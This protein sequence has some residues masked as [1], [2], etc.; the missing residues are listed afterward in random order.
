[1]EQKL[2]SRTTHMP[3]ETTRL[4]SEAVEITRVLVVDH[5]ESLYRQLAD[6]LPAG[7]S[8][9]DYA[10]S[11]DVAAA[12]IAEHE[13]D[14]VVVEVD[15]GELDG[16]AVLRRV[17]EHDPDCPVL[18][19]SAAPSFEQ[20]VTALREGAYEFL[21]KPIDSQE[22]HLTLLRAAGR[23][24]LQ[25]AKKQLLEE[26][27]QKNHDLSRRIAE[28]NALADAAALLSSTAEVPRLLSAILGLATKVTM[29][30]IG[31]IMLLEENGETLVI[32]DMIGPESE[33]LI[34]ARLPA[35]DSVAG[36][37]AQ[38]GEALKIDDVETDAQFGRVNRQRF[39]TKSLLSVP[40]KTP[41]R[42][43][44]VINLADKIGGQPFTEWDLRILRTFAAQAAAAISDSEQFQKRLR[45]L[46]EITALYEISR[47]IPTATNPEEL[48]EV[49]FDGMKTIV[50]C[51]I[52]I[53]FE[54][55]PDNRELVAV[56]L[57]NSLSPGE[58][59]QPLVIPAWPGDAKDEQG[60]TRHVL[61]AVAQRLSPGRALQSVLA[62]P[63]GES[64]TP[65]EMIVLLSV[66]PH[67]FDRHT[68]RL[69]RL[70]AAQA[71]MLYERKSA[72]LNASRLV[73]MGKMIS[74]I[75][76]DLRKP[77]TNI[78]GSLQIM[79]AKHKLP[80]KTN[81]VLESTEQEIDLLAELVSELVDFSNPK[82]YQTKRRSLG[83]VIDRALRMVAKEAQKKELRIETEFPEDLPAI[84][85]DENQILEVFLNTILNA[86][87][88][89]EAG[90][91][92]SVRG[93]T[94]NNS[95]S[96]GRSVVVEFIDTGC[97]IPNEDLA[98]IFERYYT[99]RETG[100]GLGLAIV[101]RIVQAHEGIIEVESK[102][103]C[104]CFRFIFPVG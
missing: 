12:L 74:E 20:A 70:A 68:A 73:T 55:C 103:G 24:H 85:H 3:G 99:T 18:V 93:Y 80:G 77:L 102:P 56:R 27:R 104:T 29:A 52:K 9:L 69:V 22:M 76:H 31:S 2:T 17:I 30:R 49:V 88:S 58:D 91:T 32:K 50:D 25:R 79:R 21:L 6:L 48:A 13:Y 82:K 81:Q 89:M 33:K 39:E 38:R 19:T 42:I 63:V 72:L 34:D 51:E 1:M 10:E 11:L 53:W 28:L 66:R 84:F 43:V 15:H 16:F 36:W 64:S 61:E 86:F 26:A 8:E 83:P 57:E 97:G 100:T 35:S 44:G 7:S 23:S 62:T 5:E 54:S 78:K 37:V 65:R 45:K 59:N 95:K 92:L 96:P 47:R 87:E 14:T 46:A 4:G 67:A 75:S 101:E 90:G 40:L 41:N 94:D 60:L 71:A 98:R